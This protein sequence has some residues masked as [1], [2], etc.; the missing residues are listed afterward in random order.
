MKNG[1]NKLNKF[2]SKADETAIRWQKLQQQKASAPGERQN[3]GP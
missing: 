3:G 2:Q 1:L